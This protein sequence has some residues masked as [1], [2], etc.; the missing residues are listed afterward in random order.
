MPTPLPALEINFVAAIGSSEVAS[1]KN[2]QITI[3]NHRTKLP[4]KMVFSEF[5][6]NNPLIHDFVMG[7]QFPL[8]ECVNKYSNCFGVTGKTLHIC[9][10]TLVAS[11]AELRV[12]G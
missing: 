8:L 10:A 4:I 7:V 9:I 6:R 11:P 1:V 2:P 5:C 12:P 3:G